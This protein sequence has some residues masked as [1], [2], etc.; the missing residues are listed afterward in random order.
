METIRLGNDDFIL[1]IRKNQKNGGKAFETKNN[2]L[3]RTI[4]KFIEEKDLGNK[5]SD[6][7]IPCKWNP[8]DCNDEGL[9]LPKTATQ[10]DIDICMLPKLYDFLHKLSQE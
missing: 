6:E 5:V 10:F 8:I 2:H 1:F 3:G 4:W 9:G 7:S